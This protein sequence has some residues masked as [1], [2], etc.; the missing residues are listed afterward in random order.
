MPAPCTTTLLREAF[1]LNGFEEGRHKEVLSQPGRSL[2]HRARTRAG[3]CASREH[4]EWAFMV[5]GYSECIDSF[6][7][8]GLFELARRSGFFPAELV[9]T[10]EPVIQEEGG[11]SCSSP[12]GSPGTGGRCR[13]AAAVFFLKTLAVWA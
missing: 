9:D 1:E 4:A 8:F 3:I 7:A 2:R 11:T 12:T 6:F 5:T 10:F 13:L